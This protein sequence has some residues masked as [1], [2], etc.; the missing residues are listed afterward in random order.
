VDE[1]GD[2]DRGRKKNRLKMKYP[3]RLWPFR[4]ATRAGQN[5]IAIQM[6]A[7]KIHRKTDM[8]YPPRS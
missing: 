2:D 6:V 7:V 4:S 8:T 3:M 1:V 5:A